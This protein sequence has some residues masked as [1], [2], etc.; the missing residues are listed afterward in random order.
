MSIQSIDSLS[1]RERHVFER[2]A[3]GERVSDVAREMNLS[4][5]TVST[6][7]SRLMAKLRARGNA[8]L[9]AIALEYGLRPIIQTVA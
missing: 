2:I 8:E 3:F 7:R 6:Y 4:V 5:K 1:K 9:C